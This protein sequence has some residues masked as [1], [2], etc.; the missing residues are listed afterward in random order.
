[1][2][3]AALLHPPQLLHL[4]RALS[5]DY[6][7]LQAD[8]WGSLESI[9]HGKPISAAIL[10]PM[11]DRF[12]GVANCERLIQKY[13]S[14]P[15]IAYA[16]VDARS[17]QAVARLSRI[18]L[19]DVILLDRDDYAERIKE[20]IDAS[21]S[22]SVTNGFL[23]ELR[24]SLARLPPRIAQTVEN[25]FQVPHKYA[26][27]EDLAASASVT[28][29]CLYRSF[30]SAQLS[31]P[32]KFLTAARV[33]RGYEYLLEPQFSVEHV[34]SKTGYSSTRAFGRHTREVFGTSPSKLRATMEYDT[35]LAVLHRWLGRDHIPSNPTSESLDY[36]FETQWL[37]RNSHS[38]I[39]V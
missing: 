38:R 1:M 29:S 2:S 17:I 7:I 13:P 19:R 6:Q 9:I 3:V 5:K 14:L 39:A 11:W 4:R 18:G 16:R 31:S 24:P 23:T 30:K 35:I 33:L 10:D 21:T 15:F 34:A 32:K 26:R 25:L 22:S 8:C 28:M 20:K 27:A 12:T 37:L 36:E